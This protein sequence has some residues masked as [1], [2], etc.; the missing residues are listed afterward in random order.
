MPI[1]VQIVLQYAHIFL[2]I[3][4]FGGVLTA[5]FMIL[6]VV[7]GLKPETQ[8]EFS[9]PFGARVEK[10]IIPVAIFVILLG[11]ARGL[12]VNVLS[13]F[14]VAYGW[15]WLAALFVGL[16]LLGLIPIISS[17]VHKLQATEAGPQFATLLRRIKTLTFIELSGFLV[18]LGLMIAMR[19]GY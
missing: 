6:P 8:K 16:G 2:A 13:R 9:V 14:N 7:A 1:W 4:W 17:R 11:I 10:I 3:F 5:D 18:I 15:T 12:S 19:F